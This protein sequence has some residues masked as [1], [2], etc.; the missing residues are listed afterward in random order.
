MAVTKKLADL[1]KAFVGVSEF[2]FCTTSSDFSAS[3]VWDY[4]LPILR[5]S[6]SF[7]TSEPSF[8][9]KFI[10]GESVPYVSTAEPG[11]TTMSFEIPSIDDDITGWLLTKADTPTITGVTDTVGSDEG[12]WSGSGYK[13]DNKVIQGMAMIISEDRTKA[14]L[15]RNLKGYVSVNMSELS[16][17]PVSFTI[18]ATIESSISDSKQG[19]IMFLEFTKKA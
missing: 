7:E 12:T 15:I 19:D 18:S 17:S 8:D 11:E 14:I 13:L 5:D 16:N 10:H 1:K 6:L 3:T 9:N 4:E 2:R